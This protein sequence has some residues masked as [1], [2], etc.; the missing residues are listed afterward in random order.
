MKTTPFAVAG[1]W[2][3]TA[4]PATATCERFGA[5]PQLL[6]REHALGQVRAQELE[7]VDADR[8]A[9]APVVG[10]HALP[11]RLLGQLRRLGCR[12]ERQRQLLLL[13]AAAGN[14]LRPRNEPELPQQRSP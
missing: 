1:R 4:I 12:V 7:R 3:A 10:E 11:R 2:R 9:R 14:R 6:A 5:A 8:E 13:A